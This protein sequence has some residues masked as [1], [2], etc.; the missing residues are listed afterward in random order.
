MLIYPTI[1]NYQVDG[2]FGARIQANLP[3]QGNEYVVFREGF[4]LLGF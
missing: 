1:A 4:F 3:K 2:L